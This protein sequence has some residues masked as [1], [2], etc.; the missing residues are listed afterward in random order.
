MGGG[1]RYCNGGPKQQQLQ[2]DAERA[3]HD[4][5]LF[6]MCS[7][8]ACLSQQPPVPPLCCLRL[9]LTAHN[10]SQ[11]PGGGGGGGLHCSVL[12]CFAAAPSTIPERCVLQQNFYAHSYMP[13]AAIL[14]CLQLSPLVEQRTSFLAQ[15]RGPGKYDSLGCGM[16]A[17]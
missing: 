11:R 5:S 12:G 3:V 1:G 14:P 16:P 8:L 13:E 7:S 10:Y 15:G 17:T 2:N 9:A 4:S 6:D